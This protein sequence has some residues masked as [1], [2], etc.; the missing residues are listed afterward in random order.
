MILK[1][2]G[3]QHSTGIYQEKPYDNYNLYVLDE[4][5]KYDNVYGFV[6]MMFRRNN[7]MVPYL[8]VKANVFNS[9][10][11]P[12]QINKIIGSNIDVVFDA[13]GNPS[14]LEI[15]PKN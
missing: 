13:Y 11:A 10:I 1:L 12:D 8:V 3:V 14:T 9:K 6:P 2:L 7:R 5:R 4:N 15:L